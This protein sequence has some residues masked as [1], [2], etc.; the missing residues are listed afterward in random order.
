MYSFIHPLARVCGGHC[1]LKAGKDTG[2]V[3]CKKKAQGGKGGLQWGQFGQSS[4]P[5][6]GKCRGELVKGSD[7]IFI[8]AAFPG[9]LVGGDAVEPS[10]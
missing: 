7:V 9:Q 6:A 10:G 4:G 1:I 5:R 8:K 3:R 2:C